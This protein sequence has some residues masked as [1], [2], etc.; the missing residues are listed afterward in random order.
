MIDS[1]NNDISSHKKACKK[2]NFL[3]NIQKIIV[4]LF[5]VDL[6]EIDRIAWKAV[7]FK[8]KFFLKIAAT[9]ITFLSVI[10]LGLVYHTYITVITM[11]VLI[12]CFSIA[13]I[14]IIMKDNEVKRIKRSRGINTSWELNVTG[15]AP[16]T[17]KNISVQYKNKII[18][19]NVSTEDVKNDFNLDSENPIESYFIKKL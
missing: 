6:K 4:E 9:I 17:V 10:I 16:T 14:L 15:Q 7:F 5:F 19:W 2:K 3:F 8:V 18:V 13:A 11:V 1:L 12:I